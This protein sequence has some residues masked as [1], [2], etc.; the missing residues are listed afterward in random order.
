MKNAPQ[1]EKVVIQHHPFS[2]LELKIQHFS[3]MTSK[4]KSH[5]YERHVKNILKCKSSKAT[6]TLF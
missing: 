6:S 4:A 5:V 1:N 3:T 2:T